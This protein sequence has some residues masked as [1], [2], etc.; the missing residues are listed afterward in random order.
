MGG[1]TPTF[2]DAK[3]YGA[4]YLTDFGIR[5]YNSSG[6]AFNVFYGTSAGKVGIGTTNPATKLEVVGQVSIGQQTNGTASIDAYSGAAYYGSSGA[7][8]GLRIY[9]NGNYLF[10]GSNVSDERAKENISNL[11]FNAIEKIN[12]LEPKSYY[13]KHNLKKL[14][15]GFIAQDINKILPD[16]VEGDLNSEEYI[17]LD[18]NGIITVLVKAIQEQQTQLEELKELIKNK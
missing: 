1:G 4:N 13:M 18:Y 10:T 12:A 16:L 11:D 8:N 7:E 14:R 3:G 15:Y 2:L 17:G 5:T 9:N 6:T